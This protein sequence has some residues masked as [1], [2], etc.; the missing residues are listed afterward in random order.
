MDQLG[1]DPERHPAWLVKRVLEYGRWR[2]LAKSGGALDGK[3]DLSERVTRLRSLQ[4]RALVFRCA[5]FQ[6]PPS[7]FRCCATMPSRI[8]E[9]TAPPLGGGSSDASICFRRRYFSDTRRRGLKLDLLC[10]AHRMLEPVEGIKEVSLIS[11]PD[12]AAMK[13]NT[14]ANLCSKK[15]FYDLMELLDHL[16]L[17][18]MI[19]YFTEK[20]TR[21]WIH[22]TVIRSLGWFK[23]AETEP[24][25]ISLNGTT[26]AAVKAKVSRAVSEL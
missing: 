8:G 15:D 24:D 23:D 16:E 22:P 1:I 7:F 25:P 17:Q 6:L 3:P 2:D 5:W 9:D 18:W 19:G 11:L 14:L 21:R 4:L 10:H 13:L 26:R 12:L 20:N